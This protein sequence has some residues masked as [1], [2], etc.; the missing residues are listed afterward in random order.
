MRAFVVCTSGAAA[1]EFA[2]IGSV[3]VMLLVC[4]VDFGLAFYS[5][6]QVQASAEA[7]AQYAALH[8]YNSSAVSTAAVDATP[9]MGIS[10][11]SSEFCGCASGSGVSSAICQTTCSDGTTAG[12]YVSVTASRAYSTLLSYPMVPASYSQTS[13]ST[14]RI[15]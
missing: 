6:M 5:D 7:G 1:I 9:T 15:Q 4:G 2:I 11:T 10:A 12:I 8:G 14:V 13:T 3:L